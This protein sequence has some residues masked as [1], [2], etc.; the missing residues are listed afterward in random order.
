VTNRTST[1]INQVSLCVGPGQFVR[2]TLAA[3]AQ[4][5]LDLLFLALKLLYTGLSSRTL[6]QLPDLTSSHNDVI[7]PAQS[8]V[9]GADFC[10]N[11]RERP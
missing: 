7:L 10:R 6:L 3:L 9:R 2:R 11:T 8:T 1:G 5:S 4:P